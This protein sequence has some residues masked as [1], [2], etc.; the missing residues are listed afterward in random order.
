MI[1]MK[2]ALCSLFLLLFVSVNAQDNPQKS[3]QQDNDAKYEDHYKQ[4]ANDL[5]ENLKARINLDESQ[6][7]K[8]SDILVEYNRRVWGIKYHLVPGS[9]NVS[10]NSNSADTNDRA[11]ARSDD[12]TD[13]T[14]PSDKKQDE[15]QGTTRSNDSTNY[16]AGLGRD[17]IENL[18]DADRTADQDIVNVLNPT[19][20]QKYVADKTDWWA[21]VKDRIYNTSYNKS[22]QGDMKQKN[23]S[24]KKESPDHDNDDMK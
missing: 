23:D 14:M 12:K 10:M 7:S 11:A 9:P 17:E 15:Y 22:L 2:I 8:I 18:R 19:Q 13:N 21:V 24:E 3:T 20:K 5:A 4:T 16:Y 6:V 1:K